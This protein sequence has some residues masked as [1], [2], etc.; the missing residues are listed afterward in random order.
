MQCFGKDS[1]LTHRALVF[2]N[3][4]FE[5]LEVDTHIEA[6]GITLQPDPIHCGENIMLYRQYMALSSF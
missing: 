6:R 5:M 4:T 1:S 2:N 3:T